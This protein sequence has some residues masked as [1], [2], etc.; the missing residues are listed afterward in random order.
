MTDV[1][2]RLTFC[3]GFFTRAEMPQRRLDAAN[4]PWA[5]V[6][7]K[8]QGCEASMRMGSFRGKTIENPYLFTRR[9]SS[10]SALGAPSFLASPIALTGSSLIAANIVVQQGSK[11]RCV[12]Q[13]LPPAT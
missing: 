2:V 8:S 5:S 9:D 13:S 3:F 6:R 12:T 10:A 1:D 4:I 7:H 11:Q